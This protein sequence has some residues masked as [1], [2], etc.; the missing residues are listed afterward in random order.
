MNRDHDSITSRKA[1]HLVQSYFPGRT[2]VDLIFGW[3]NQSLKQWES[4][5]TTALEYADDHIS[6]YQLTWER[7]TK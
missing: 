5:L 2:S 4:D 1:I 7:G 3:P 6:M